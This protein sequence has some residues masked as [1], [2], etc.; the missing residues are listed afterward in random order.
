MTSVVLVDQSATSFSVYNVGEVSA[1]TLAALKATF[2]LLNP[3]V[4]EHGLFEVFTRPHPP[5][6]R[7]FL[8][9]EISDNKKHLRFLVYSNQNVY[10]TVVPNA[11]P[12]LVEALSACIPLCMPYTA[13][14][15]RDIF[16]VLPSE[17]PV[18]CDLGSSE[19]LSVSP[20]AQK[21][22]K[23][24]KCDPVELVPIVKKS[25]LQLFLE[26]NTVY[27]FKSQSV[28]VM[29]S[30][31]VHCLKEWVKL[32]PAVG[33]PIGVNQDELVKEIR[34]DY[35]DHLR[36]VD[37]PH[38][39]VIEGL[40]MVASKKRRRAEPASAA[41]ATSTQSPLHC[42]DVLPPEESEQKVLNVNEELEAMMQYKHLGENCLK[43]NQIH[44]GR[45]ETFTGFVAH[46]NQ[47]CN[48]I[49]AAQTAEQVKVILGQFVPVPH[50]AGAFRLWIPY[51]VFRLECT[52]KM[53]MLDVSL[54]QAERQKL[55]K[56]HEMLQITS[57]TF[58]THW[59]AGALVFRYPILLLLK[60]VN[61]RMLHNN[62]SVVVEFLQM[63]RE[64]NVTPWRVFANRPIVIH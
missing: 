61:A 38:G 15:R 42:D 35:S 19:A 57:S 48:T 39:T 20:V 55:P 23:K 63:Q 10:H 45:R 28:C 25:H 30:D 43:V 1:D 36:V 64:W 58:L 24:P 17:E 14:Y 5:F 12:L 8:N 26:S 11:T 47:V 56:L 37:T 18:A 34:Q 9:L 60:N 2:Q 44:F 52:I 16:L 49:R 27:T 54:D 46:I 50:K 59:R 7:E 3:R 32:N 51:T 41:A 6:S 33:V 13:Q 31:F 40:G 62:Q 21:K 53:W 4:L 29:L 22:I